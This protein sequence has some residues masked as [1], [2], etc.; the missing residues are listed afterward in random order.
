MTAT[1]LPDQG[2]LCKRDLCVPREKDQDDVIGKGN[3]YMPCTKGQVIVIVKL[4]SFMQVC[5]GFVEADTRVS[6]TGKDGSV[7]HTFSAPFTTRHIM[8]LLG[9]QTM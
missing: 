7:F 2:A 3:L 6:S 8:M 5:K 9:L 1:E 4:R